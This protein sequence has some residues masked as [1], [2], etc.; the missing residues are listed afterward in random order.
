MNKKK[1]GAA[2]SVVA[3]VTAGATA[4]ASTIN[5]LDT[6]RNTN[7]MIQPNYQDK[8]YDYY[9]LVKA[10]YTNDL[11]NTA[12][13]NQTRNIKNTKDTEKEVAE[14]EQNAKELLS[15]TISV[16]KNNQIEDN[17]SENVE[18]DTKLVEETYEDEKRD[19]SVANNEIE[20]SPSVNEKIEDDVEESQEV[21]TS[22]KDEQEDSQPVDESEENLVGYSDKNLDEKEVDTSDEDEQ[23]NSQLVD[24]SEENLVEYEDENLDED[25]ENSA[26]QLEEI[27]SSEDS[28]NYLENNEKEISVDQ[29]QE[30]DEIS[31]LSAENNHTEVVKFVNVEALNLRNTKLVDSNSN[32]VRTLIAGDKVSGIIEDEWLKTN[33]GYLNL[34]YLSNDYPQ[35]L[36]E[37]IESKRKAEEEA[38]IEEARI[39]EEEAKKLEEEK[40][41][42]A[43]EAQ[44]QKVEQE[45][46]QEKQNQSQAEQVEE[47]GQAFTGWVYNTNV[48]NV[49]DKAQN[50]RILGG[51]SRGT[52]VSG[53]ILDGW[54]KFNYNGKTAYTSAAYLSTKEVNN[55]PE[56]QATNN[57][58]NQQANQPVEETIEQEEVI[59]EQEIIVEENKQEAPVANTN[60]QQAANIAGGF[61]GS[62]Y[63]WGASNPSIGFDCSGLTKYVYQQLGVNLPHS[64][65][66]Q[67]GSGYAVNINSLQPGDLVFFSNRGSLDHVGIVVSSDGTFIHASTPKSGVKYDNVYSTY[68]QNVFSGAR[69]IF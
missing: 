13:A 60:G 7:S 27:S 48:L 55:E 21:D 14:I 28:T 37:E 22:D 61:V 66:A 52:K 31:N 51:L 35:N 67:F 43:K 50:G 57:Q 68:Y 41:R 32:V 23:E 19:H 54:V 4:Y 3:A 29:D 40:A 15:T 36:V 64:S 16:N 24:E 1:I 18:D 47:K 65:G 62:P 49:R 44:Q 38:I 39:K 30:V 17:I 20:V 26:D 33:E 6:D 25:D 2:L 69:R 63:V 46:S 10:D 56:V 12:I 5:N 34:S 45:A 9:S 8:S 59:E 53:E 11:K 58:Q 42:K